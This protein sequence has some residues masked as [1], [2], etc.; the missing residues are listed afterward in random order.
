MN[1]MLPLNDPQ[2][3]KELAK[4]NLDIVP[5]VIFS[6]CLIVVSKILP[7]MLLIFADRFGTSRSTTIR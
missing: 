4:I 5:N 7:S 3:S 6:G 1:F 2:C